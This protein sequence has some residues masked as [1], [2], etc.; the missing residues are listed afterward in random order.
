MYKDSSHFNKRNASRTLSVR[1]LQQTAAAAAPL[2]S[3]L[4]DD[5]R[6]EG[7]DLVPG[8][9]RVLGAL[10]RRHLLRQ[11]WEGILVGRKSVLFLSS[12]GPRSWTQQQQQQS[13]SCVHDV[14]NF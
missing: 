2:P 3:Y 9:G 7:A 14:V 12:A 4:G 13:I 5:G 10:G 8:V 11:G 6:L 1:V